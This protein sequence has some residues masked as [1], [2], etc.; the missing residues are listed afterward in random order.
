MSKRKHSELAV[1]PAQADASLVDDEHTFQNLNLDPRLNQALAKMKFAKPTLVQAKA[2]PLALQGKDILARAKTG[3][4]K[5][6]AY[7]LPVLHHILQTKTATT[8]PEARIQSLILVP[9]RELADQVSKVLDRL[10]L[11]C[12]KHIKYVNITKPVADSVTMTTLSTNPDIVIATPSKA[13]WIVKKVQQEKFQGKLEL[14]YLVIDEADLVLSYGYDED[15]KVLSEYIKSAGLAVQSILM[16]ATMTKEVDILKRFFLRSP[17]ILRLNDGNDESA[18]GKL[19][20]YC[21]KCGE[22]EKFLLVYV[23]FK[24]KLIKGKTIIFVG[25]IDRCYRLKLFLE[26]F[27]LKSV[28]LNSELPV[29]SRLHVV[30]QFNKNIY[31]IIIASDENEVL[32]NE[33]EEEVEIKEAEE[34]EIEEGKTEDK[35]VEMK[36]DEAEEKEEEKAESDAESEDSD[37]ESDKDEEMKD[38][39]ENVESTKSDKKDKK[40]EKSKPTP[41]Q[42]QKRKRK[43]KK[44]REYGI[45]RGLDFQNVACILNFDLPSTSKSYTHRVGRTARAGASGMALSFVIPTELYGKHKA[46]TYAPSQNDEKVLAKIEK[47]QKKRGNEILPYTF[48]MK[49]VEAFRYRMEDALRAV[50]RGAVREA[51][52]KELKQEILASEKLARFF[53]ENPD[54]AAHLRHDGELRSARVQPHLKHVPTYLLP[55]GGVT[56]TQ[57]PAM[58]PFKKEVGNRIRQNRARK[59]RGGRVNKG[60][61]DDRKR[62]PLK[63]FKAGF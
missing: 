45:S 18:A 4:G 47:S 37:A 28:V 49:Q 38:G 42:Q 36:D 57:A 53:E 7:L 51:R 10:T 14:K 43:P 50:T 54:D 29:N 63:T 34:V 1:A 35:D 55:S 62:D 41:A 26:Q 19:L 22:E 46:T 58:V 61:G 21:V 12:N 15:V 23:I 11:Y 31:D 30:E 56:T 32:R 27:G 6:I 33:D 52:V 17:A 20:Q 39:D 59:M 44:D 25:D 9:T 5:T 24:L 60:K 13:A 8:T 2:V 40:K 16:S 48:D 3:S